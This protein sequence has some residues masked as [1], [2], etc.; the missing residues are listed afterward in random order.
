MAGS[1]CAY[2]R[3][4]VINAALNDTAF[5]SPGTLYVALST[6]AFSA[7]ATGSAMTEVSTTSTGYGRVAVTANTTN[8]PSSTSGTTSNGT[9]I[10]F[11]T[12]TGSW[13]TVA[14]FYITDAATGGNCLYGGDLSTSR[15]VNSGDTASFANGNL[16]VTEQ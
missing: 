15:A 2:F 7:S 6:G 5:T 4:V 8:F 1:K 3:N 14:S 13:G 10:T 9:T 12:A 11:P 16:T